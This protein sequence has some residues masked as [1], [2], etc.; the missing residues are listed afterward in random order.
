MEKDPKYYSKICSSLQYLLDCGISA[1]SDSMHGKCDKRDFKGRRLGIFIMGPEGNLSV[2]DL[3]SPNA[4]LKHIG[5]NFPSSL[6]RNPK[7]SKKKDYNNAAKNSVIPL[8]DILDIENVY[9]QLDSD[10]SRSC[11]DSAMRVLADTTILNQTC[12]RSDTEVVGETYLG[13]T[14]RYIL[15]CFDDVAYHPGMYQNELNQANH[16]NFTD[17]YNWDGYA[18]QKF[19]YSGGK[20]M[21]FLA[22]P[23]KEIG[24]KFSS[25]QIGSGGFGGSCAEIGKRYGP[26][27]GPTNNFQNI[28]YG[29]DDVEVGRSQFQKE[30][31]SPFATDSLPQTA[32]SN[33]HE[34]YQDLGIDCSYY[35]HSV[36]IFGLVNQTD[37]ENGIHLGFNYLRLLNDRSGGNGPIVVSLSGDNAH[38]DILE[39]EVLSRSTLT[40]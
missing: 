7:F 1:S 9:V 40:R 10:Y 5:V 4:H 3:K 15:D 8:S 20:I 37:D 24:T 22:G 34:Y 25:G 35:A 2:F 32:Y 33:V 21:C 6:R 23:P 11:I 27:E 30:K 16:N 12:L 19:L 14:I 39:K 31:T 26:L 18:P 28:V 17:G 38:D 29:G 13:S 36:E